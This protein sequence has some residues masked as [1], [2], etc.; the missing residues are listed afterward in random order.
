MGQ[1]VQAAHN[2][3]TCRGQ[4]DK[5]STAAATAAV[6]VCGLEIRE[7]TPLKGSMQPYCV[8]QC[9]CVHVRAVYFCL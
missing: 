1:L 7:V 8:M 4:G 2:S 5:T 9:H 3:T 6:C